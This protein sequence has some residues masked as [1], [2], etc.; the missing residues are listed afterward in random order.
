MILIKRKRWVRIDNINKKKK[1]KL[2]T[3]FEGAIPGGLYQFWAHINR[4]PKKN[5]SE[6]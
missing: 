2:T 4:A 5:L 1:K 6:I 3:I